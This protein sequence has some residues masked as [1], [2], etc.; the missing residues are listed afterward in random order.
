MA[1]ADSGISE[2]SGPQILIVDDFNDALD[3]YREYLTFKGFR[4]LTARSG[5]ECLA[6]AREQ[7]PAVIFLDIRMSLMTGTETVQILRADPAFRATPIVA[8]TAYALEDER[9]AA[10]LAGFDEVITKPCLPD[11]LV[12]AVERLISQQR[13]PSSP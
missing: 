13:Q 5:A 4:V 1:N 6:V 3:M 2:P 7:R 8:L 12:A 10:L 9:V 11:D